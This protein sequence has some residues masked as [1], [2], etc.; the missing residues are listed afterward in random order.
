MT[1]ATTLTLCAFAGL[2][3]LS[4]CDQ[5]D[6]MLRT[7]RWEPTGANAGNIAAMVADPH[8]LI[9]GHG[10]L[11]R[12]SNDQSLAATRIMTDQPKA[13]SGGGGGGGAAPS[14]GGSGAPASPGS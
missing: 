4:G 7:D 9:R 1:R 14:G 10:D 8:D 11:F 5:L 6:P 3:T 2:L 12:E 13:F